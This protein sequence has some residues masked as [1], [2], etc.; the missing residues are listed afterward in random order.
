MW[1]RSLVYKDL[2]RADASERDN[3]LIQGFV[4]SRFLQ[5]NASGAV[6]VLEWIILSWM[7]KYLHEGHAVCSLLSGSCWYL[8]I[9]QSITIKCNYD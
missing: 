7:T 3:G 5:P 9:M 4:V 1:A 8:N 2:G 6:A